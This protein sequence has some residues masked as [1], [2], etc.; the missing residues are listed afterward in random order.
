M[1]FKTIKSNFKIF[2]LNGFNI[3]LNLL[4]IGFQIDYKIIIDLILGFKLIIIA[5]SR[6]I[7]NYD[8]IEIKIKTWIVTFKESLIKIKDNTF[9]KEVTEINFRDKETGVYLSKLPN[10]FFK[11]SVTRA[12]GFCLIFFSSA[13]IFKN[14]PSIVFSVTYFAKSVSTFCAIGSLL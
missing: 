9:T 1:N 5:I 7:L 12:A 11:I 10:T 2:K 14:S 8:C 13:A 3:I 4:T 6:M